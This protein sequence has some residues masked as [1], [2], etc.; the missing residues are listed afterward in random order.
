MKAT[1]DLGVVDEFIV[2]VSAGVPSIVVLGVVGIDV[3]VLGIV[4]H[5]PGYMDN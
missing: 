2:E 5:K 4:D 3:V 1:M